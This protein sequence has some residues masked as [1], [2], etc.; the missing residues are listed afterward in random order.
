MGQNPGAGTAAEAMNEFE[1]IERIVA[2][3]RDTASGN[4]VV[5]GPGDD[6]AVLEIPTGHQLVVSTDTLVA[7]RHYPGG[8]C[9]DAIG[10]RSLAV[11]T[12]DL[13]AMGASPAFATVSLTAEGLTANWAERYADGLAAAAQ[14]FDVAIVGGNIARGPESITVTVHGHVPD[15]AAI[16]R[17]GAAPGDEVYVTGSLGGAGLALA[18]ENLGEWS[19]VALKDESPLKRYWMPEPRLRLGIGLRGIATAAIDISDGLSSDLDHLCRASGVGCDVDLDTIPL[20]PGATAM[21]AVAAGDDYELAFAAQRDARG[22]IEAL[23]RMHGI[24]ITRLAAL[25]E[26][27]HPGVRWTRHGVAAG[28]RPGYRHFK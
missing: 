11:A 19:L 17:S 12:S 16:T 18:D 13:A 2:R 15:G 6:A 28:V 3:L 7:D 4:G 24:R 9:A 23:S 20:Y 27:V 8:A 14:A 25:R 1:L 10:Y 26:D 5:L 22:T 21:D